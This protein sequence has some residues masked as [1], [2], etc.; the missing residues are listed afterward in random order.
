MSLRTRIALAAALA[1]ALAVLL[2]SFAAYVATSRTL[3]DQVDRDLR[4]QA[5]VAIRSLSRPGGGDFGGPVRDRFGGSGVFVQLVDAAGNPDR[6]PA[7]VAALPASPAAVA[8]ARGGNSSYSSIEVSGTRLR[9]LAI[10]V[11]SGLALQVARSAKEVDDSLASL[12]SVL[13]AVSGAGILVAALLGLVVA[14]RGLRPVTRLTESVEHVARTHDLSHRIPVQGTDEPARLAMTFNSMLAGLEQARAAQEQLVADASHELRT[15]LAALRTNAELLASGVEI[16][17]EERRRIAQDVATQIDGFG[18]LVS[19][20]VE[21]T[22]GERAAPNPEELR[23]DELVEDAVARARV[24]HPGVPFTVTVRPSTVVA[25]ARLLERAV[26]NLLDNAVRHGAPPV[27]VEVAD[28]AVR[29]RDHGA[30]VAPED[31]E[32]VFARFWRSPDARAREGSGLGLS[33]VHQVA[34]AHGGEATVEDAPGGG[35]LFTI[36]LPAGAPT[37]PSA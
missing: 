12:R 30:G 3:N 34:R 9:V 15:P 8:A 25:D 1:V 19:D 14:T 29:V 13:L 27:E 17:D 20:L 10:P 7:S 24:N 21:L 37:A 22:R 18:R 23:L 36:R 2:V 26:A 6:L 32:R 4:E 31:R 33:I 11:G 16:D 35:A 28:G 5:E